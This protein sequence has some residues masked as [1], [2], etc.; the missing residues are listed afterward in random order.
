MCRPGG[1]GDDGEH[2]PPDVPEKQYD[3]V[4]W[5]PAPTR[6]A[7][8]LDPFGGSGTTA[9]TARALG[10]VGISLDLSADYQR[11]AKWRIY[12]SGHGSK[13]RERTNRE[14]QVSLF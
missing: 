1:F 5:V 7:V 8:V 11:L 6:P 9:L 10:R 2:P 3:L 4:N 12:E 13:V 14:A